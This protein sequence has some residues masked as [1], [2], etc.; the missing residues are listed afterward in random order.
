MKDS[1]SQI[2]IKFFS[3]F[4]HNKIKS[5]VETQTKTPHNQKLFIPIDTKLFEW[6]I[7][8]SFPTHQELT[9]L[10]YELNWKSGES[11]A[12]WLFDMLAIVDN[13][14]VVTAEKI[15]E[16]IYIYKDYLSI[17]HFDHLMQLYSSKVGNQY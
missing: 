7:K 5:F 15:A 1:Y 14:E 8:F 9:D 16:Y 13:N 17:E 3:L 12:G 2:R 6:V 10:A 4:V 11:M